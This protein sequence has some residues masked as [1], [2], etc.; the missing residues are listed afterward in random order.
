MKEEPA[1]ELDIVAAAEMDLDF[2]GVEAELEKR[3]ESNRVLEAE[4]GEGKEKEKSL[5]EME[6]S[7]REAERDLE[8]PRLPE[9]VSGWERA[10]LAAPNNSEVW[11]RYSSFH[12]TSG[13]IE[14][15]LEYASA[16]S[17]KYGGE[18]FSKIALGNLKIPA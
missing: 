15:V 4:L 12:I 18:L 10:V 17:V 1:S 14:K 13:E 2:D 9:D 6:D 5:E 3:K 11:L 16:F 8:V 7:A